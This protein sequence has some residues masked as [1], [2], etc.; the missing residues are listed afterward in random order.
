M[1]LYIANNMVLYVLQNPRNNIPEIKASLSQ[2]KCHKMP[3][4][5][6]NYSMLYPI[7]SQSLVLWGTFTNIAVSFG[8]LPLFEIGHKGTSDSYQCHRNTLGRWLANLLIRSSFEGEIC[9]HCCV[10]ESSLSLI[11][12]ITWIFRGSLSHYY[13][14]K[15]SDQQYMIAA[16]IRVILSTSTI[17][18]SI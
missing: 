13:N 12:C 16:L 15:L 3:T 11:S 4:N 7:S 1:I 10:K 6:G 14:Y 5:W 2:L 18:S 9:V 8:R 17:I